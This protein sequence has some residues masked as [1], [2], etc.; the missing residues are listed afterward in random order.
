MDFQKNYQKLYVADQESNER[1]MVACIHFFVSKSL[2]HIRN[3][4]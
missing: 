3:V 4:S 1:K 2:V